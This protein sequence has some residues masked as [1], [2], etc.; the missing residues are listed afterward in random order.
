MTEYMSEAEAEIF[1]AS[2]QDPDGILDDIVEELSRQKSLKQAGKFAYTCADL[3]MNHLER[4][5]VLGEEFG[6]AAH[7]V[8]EGNGGRP[9]DEKKLRTELVQ[10]A[11]V[12]VAWIEALDKSQQKKENT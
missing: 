1:F 6:E 10:V 8:N 3:E 9:I 7:E 12:C 2:A 4:F 5:A 11:A